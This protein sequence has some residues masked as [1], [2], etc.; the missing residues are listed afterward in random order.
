MMPFAERQAAFQCVR[1]KGTGQRED[2]VSRLAPCPFCDGTGTPENLAKLREDFESTLRENDT[3]RAQL[4]AAHHQR[5]EESHRIRI[6][7]SSIQSY[8]DHLG[9]G[10]DHFRWQLLLRDFEKLSHRRLETLEERQ[11]RRRRGLNGL[12]VFVCFNE[13]ARYTIEELVKDP[14]LDDITEEE[15]RAIVAECLSKNHLCLDSSGKLYQPEE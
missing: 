12:A 13:G 7:A 3:L 1:C 6:L 14:Y 10:K 4:E 9:S 2:G 5:E 15:I 11:A 8:E